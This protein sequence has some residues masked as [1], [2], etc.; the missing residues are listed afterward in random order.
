MYYLCVRGPLRNKS[1]PFV[2]SNYIPPNGGRPNRATAA[3]AESYAGKPVQ[4]FACESGKRTM[5]RQ[6]WDAGKERCGLGHFISIC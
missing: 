4:M 2:H 5:C 3:D 1:S 6:A